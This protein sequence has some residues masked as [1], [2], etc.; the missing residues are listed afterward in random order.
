MFLYLLLTAEISQIIAIVC[1]LDNVVS[2]F[3]CYGNY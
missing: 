1:T 3:V 2:L